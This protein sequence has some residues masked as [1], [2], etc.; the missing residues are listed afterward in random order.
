M[1]FERLTLSLPT[2]FKIVDE[3]KQ[4]NTGIPE[5][6]VTKAKYYD[7]LRSI[8]PSRIAKVESM[9]YS[10]TPNEKNFVSWSQINQMMMTVGKDEKTRNSSLLIS[11]D[12]ILHEIDGKSYSS[13]LP[14]SMDD[15]AHRNYIVFFAIHEN[16]SRWEYL[17][18]RIKKFLGLTSIPCI[19][20]SSL[21]ISPYIL[22]HKKANHEDVFELMIIFNRFY[23]LL[24]RNLD[25]IRRINELH[26]GNKTTGDINNC[27]ELKSLIRKMLEESKEY[28]KKN[29]EMIKELLESSGWDMKK[30][31]FGSLPTRV[32]W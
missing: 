12:E 20:D 28:G 22:L 1:N 29:L 17:F 18:E 4:K 14:I 21:M 16:P 6:S 8:H 32:K 3:E 9:L 5:M 10:S 11:L 27:E 15:H 2:I 26:R 24:E 23:Q 13:M 31:M 7:E 30:F 19:V 25:E